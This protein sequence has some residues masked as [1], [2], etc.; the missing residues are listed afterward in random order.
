MYPPME[1]SGFQYSNVPPIY[2]YLQEHGH[3]NLQIILSQRFFV[4]SYSSPFPIDSGKRAKKLSAWLCDEDRKLNHDEIELD[5]DIQ[6]GE[7]FQLLA[8]ISSGSLSIHACLPEEG[9]GEAEDLNYSIPEAFE[10]TVS[11]DERITAKPKVWWR[12]EGEPCNRR[13][14]G[15]PGIK[16]LLK[17]KEFF[18]VEILASHPESSRPVERRDEFIH[19]ETFSDSCRV[20]HRVDPSNVSLDESVWESMAAYALRLNSTIISGKIERSISP[21]LIKDVY[22]AVLRSGGEGLRKEELSDSIPM[23]GIFYL[24]IFLNLLLQ[25]NDNPEYYIDFSSCLCR[26]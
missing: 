23:L 2:F 17:R 14:K 22:C 21:S 24:Q 18:M 6:C 5:L 13:E 12:K 19:A 20:D 11:S 9:V 1:S 26:Q 10:G 16:I 4:N 25:E 3:G 8:L 15:F 7:I